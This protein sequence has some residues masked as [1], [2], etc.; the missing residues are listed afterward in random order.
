MLKAIRVR[1]CHIEKDPEKYRD[2]LRDP[3]LACK[4][5]EHVRVTSYIWIYSEVDVGWAELRDKSL[6]GLGSESFCVPL[7]YCYYNVL[8]LV[9][10]I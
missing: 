7:F 8:K 6:T 9:K 10:T 2:P 3:Q 1:P 5:R 4:S